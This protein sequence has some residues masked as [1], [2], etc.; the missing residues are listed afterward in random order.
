MTS[1]CES[2]ADESDDTGAFS[3]LGNSAGNEPG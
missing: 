3:I 2:E 1:K